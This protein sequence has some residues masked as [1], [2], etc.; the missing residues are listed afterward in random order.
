[1]SNRRRRIRYQPSK[2]Q[3]IFTGIIGILFCIIGFAVVLPGAGIFGLVWTGIAVAITV[4]SFM[5]AAGKKGFM[6]SYVIEDEGGAAPEG[7][8]STEQR[9]QELQNLY[10]RRLITTEEYEAKRQEI[11]KE[12]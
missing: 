8:K 3:S 12:L 10:D 1:M 9:L 7:E 5:Q 4:S 2:G 6:G 11:L